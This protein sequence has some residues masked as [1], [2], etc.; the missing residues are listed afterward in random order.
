MA[1]ILN[2]C[3]ATTL[4]CPHFCCLQLVKSHSTR[5]SKTTNTNFSS[6]KVVSKRVLF[7]SLTEGMHLDL[8]DWTNHTWPQG[9]FPLWFEIFFVN[10]RHSEHWNSTKCSVPIE[11]NRKMLFQSVS[12]VFNYMRQST[13]KSAAST[14]NYAFPNVKR[15]RKWFAKHWKPILNWK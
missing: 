2:C 15:N 8:S 14:T 13:T 11:N 5:Y 7:L 4:I 1:R 12:N 10:L 3:S 6:I 9:T